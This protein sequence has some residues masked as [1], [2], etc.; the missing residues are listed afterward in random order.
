MSLL[1]VAVILAYVTALRYATDSRDG[2]DWQPRPP[3]VA[4]P[5]RPAQSPVSRIQ[6]RYNVATQMRSVHQQRE[7]FVSPPLRGKV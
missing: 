7:I 2:R 5:S 4:T 6:H 1:W 3:A